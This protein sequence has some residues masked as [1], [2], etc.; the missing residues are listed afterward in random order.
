MSTPQK[1][2]STDTTLTTPAFSWNPITNANR[3]IAELTESANLIKNFFNDNAKNT[4]VN[5]NKL[6]EE[7]R[8]AMDNIMKKVTGHIDG[9]KSALDKVDIIS[10][11]FD[12]LQIV[13]CSSITQVLLII[14]QTLHHLGFARSVI[15]GML[16]HVAAWWSKSSTE[17]E[18]PQPGCFQEPIPEVSGAEYLP[19]IPEEEEGSD[20]QH[21]CCSACRAR[22][23]IDVVR[24]RK[25]WD[26]LREKCFCPSTFIIFGC[27]C[28]TCQL[29]RVDNEVRKSTPETPVEPAEAQMGFGEGFNLRELATTVIVA[30]GSLVFGT[31][32][33]KSQVAK[34]LA[35]FAGFC[36][37][38]HNISLGIKALSFLKEGVCDIFRWL[39]Q[40]TLWYLVPKK[41]RGGELAEDIRVWYDAVLSFDDPLKIEK[42]GE[43]MVLR[44]E[45][46]CLV[47]E[48]QKYAEIFSGKGQRKPVFFEKYLERI[49][50]LR[51]LV[52]GL[53]KHTSVREEPFSVQ[54][55]GEPGKGKSV[56]MPVFADLLREKGFEFPV[57]KDHATYSRATTGDTDAYWT[58]YS[59]Q[60][61]VMMDDLFQITTD[62]SPSTAEFIYMKSGVPFSVPM[63]SN[64]EKGRMFTS[65]VILSTTNVPYPQYNH[66]HSSEALWRRRDLLVRVMTFGPKPADSTDLTHMRFALHD[67]L[68]PTRAPSVVIN[69]HQLGEVM[70]ARMQEFS[71]SRKNATQALLERGYSAFAFTPEQLI[72]RGA[73]QD[74][75]LEIPHATMFSIVCDVS[76][77]GALKREERAFL[78]RN[79]EPRYDLPLSQ[80]ETDET[81]YASLELS[82]MQ[83]HGAAREYYSQFGLPPME[84]LE[85]ERCRLHFTR[86]RKKFNNKCRGFWRFGCGAGIEIGDLV[87]TTADWMEACRTI[88]H[89][90]ACFMWDPNRLDLLR[91]A[92]ACAKFYLLPVQPVEDAHAQAGDMED[93]DIE[94]VKLGRKYVAL[95]FYFII[96]P[97]DFAHANYH[98]TPRVNFAHMPVQVRTYAQEFEMFEPDRQS[99]IINAGVQLAL[100]DSMEAQEKEIAECNKVLLRDRLKSYCKEYPKTAF[101]IG[102][103]SACLCAWGAYKGI[104][105][106]KGLFASE[107][108]ATI[109]SGDFATQR[110]PRKSYVEKSGAQGIDKWHGDHMKNPCYNNPDDVTNAQARVDFK[111]LRKVIAQNA[112]RYGA[113]F[114]ITRAVVS[115]LVPAGMPPLAKFLV[116]WPLGTV[117]SGILAQGTNRRAEDHSNQCLN[118]ID[119]SVGVE[120]VRS[121]GYLRDSEYILPAAMAPLAQAGNCVA[122]LEII[123]NCIHSSLYLVKN[124]KDS[125]L[126]GLIVRGN[127]LLVPC[128]FLQEPIQEAQQLGEAEITLALMRNEQW[129]TVQVALSDIHAITGKDAALLKLKTFTSHPD[130]VK[131]FIR[132]KHAMELRPFNGIMV[133]K[134][135]NTIKSM[136]RIEARPLSHCKYFAKESS[137]SV[138]DGIEYISSCK[139]GD[140]GSVVVANE[141][142]FPHKIVGMHVYGR[143]NSALG[144]AEVITCEDL[145]EGFDTLFCIR[146][147]PQPTT[148]IVQEGAN[149]RRAQQLCPPGDVDFL[150]A[151]LSN[152]EVRQP[153]RSDI[154]PSLIQNKAFE[155]LSGPAVLV[156]S[157]PRFTGEGTPLR[158]GL[159]KFSETTQPFKSDHI[160][161]AKEHLLGTLQQV[162]KPYHERRLTTDHEAVNGNP[163][164]PFGMLSTW[165]PLLECPMSAHGNP[166]V[167]GSDTY[168]PEMLARTQLQT[169]RW[170]QT[171]GAGSLYSNWENAP[172]PYG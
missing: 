96:N 22:I 17:E 106:L 35:D 44:E 33:G 18:E 3:G 69:G 146:P 148:P 89:R 60:P 170:Q 165:R 147:A 55:F 26:A 91:E 152:R 143:H 92:L 171:M 150:G 54:F 30:V 90:L 70:L 151:V 123:D 85:P 155:C 157:D 20:Q 12:V 49:M 23:A 58:G 6:V 120:R 8:A 53:R 87:V 79:T 63:S 134:H 56:V 59:G 121:Q 41:W 99:L 145:E 118:M 124:N 43:S 101:A 84:L 158:N 31:S 103:L 108:E 153:T 40:H 129:I 100:G 130:I 122:S 141:N 73:Q 48:G 127:Y 50:A 142:N 2:N 133:G 28:K 98:L 149:F 160:Q 119:P 140:C 10:I 62:K 169:P 83:C 139:D 116:T 97:P 163:Y 77:K 14:C 113:N 144:G 9:L 105:A 88:Q 75:A 86:L 71:V 161:M 19:I 109:P 95:S 45:V 93:L 112:L 46:Y 51:K 74:P 172:Q 135:A 34:I 104:M 110:Q 115:Q 102:A 15:H 107:P 21:A 16:A 66:L 117:M 11:V 168:S 39:F 162:T 68:V 78:Q 7:V 57:S 136:E 159:A 5:V 72:A 67:P 65:R 82:S 1:Q 42:L 166:A 154:I 76:N 111:M 32:P 4:L 61:I 25:S 128:H 138:L 156:P 64:E 164:N 13:A 137:Y 94:M 37:N 80:P 52:E 131:H 36:R 132:R 38:T 125:V 24:D 126:R 167:R 27:N 81:L 29:F 47:T 114:L